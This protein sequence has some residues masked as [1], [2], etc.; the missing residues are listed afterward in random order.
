MGSIGG[1]SDEQK[2][3]RCPMQFR[4]VIFLVLHH[5]P[6][7]LFVCLNSLALPSFA[8]AVK[9]PGVQDDRRCSEV[10]LISEVGT[11]SALKI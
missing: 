8:A 3:S 5:A 10:N 4:S 9:A 2:F 1:R 7:P 11:L 6:P